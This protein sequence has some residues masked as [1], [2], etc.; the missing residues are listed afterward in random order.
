MLPALHDEETK[1]RKPPPTNLDE[2][3]SRL[4][5]ERLRNPCLDFPVEQR[6]SCASHEQQQGG[7]NTT[8]SAFHPVVTISHELPLYLCDGDSDMEDDGC[9]LMEEEEEEKH[10]QRSRLVA[11]PTDSGTAENGSVFPLSEIQEEDENS[12]EAILDDGVVDDKP[13]TLTMD[14]GNLLGNLFQESDQLP[15]AKSSS[16]YP[17]L[18]TGVN[19][20]TVVKR[21]TST[22]MRQ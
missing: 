20:N 13:D 4:V 17:I 15:F 8:S 22:P 3:L 18:P 9:S 5:E 21:A 7:L 14:V 12:M 10:T 11:H 1:T 6:S 19:S 16:S 2:L